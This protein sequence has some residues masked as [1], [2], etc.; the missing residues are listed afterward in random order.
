[1]VVQEELSAIILP[2][3]QSPL[4][5]VPEI[6]PDSSIL[7]HLRVLA[8]TPVQLEPGHSARYVSCYRSDQLS[9]REERRVEAI[10]IGP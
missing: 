6:S 1:M 7:N 10:T 4:P 8:F 2:A 9:R 5:T 3:P